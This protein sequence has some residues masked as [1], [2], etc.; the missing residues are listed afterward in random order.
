M[1]PHQDWLE[2]EGIEG[3]TYTTMDDIVRTFGKDEH[4]FSWPMSIEVH[5]SKSGTLGSVSVIQSAFAEGGNTKHSM[6][7]LDYLVYQGNGHL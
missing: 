7:P 5:H 6:Q 3:K 4:G 1:P 2:P